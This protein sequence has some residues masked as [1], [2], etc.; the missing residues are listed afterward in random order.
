MDIYMEDV[1]KSHSLIK[2][3]MLFWNMVCLDLVGYLTNYMSIGV[4][5]TVTVC[6]QD[7]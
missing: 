3:Y 5:I 7:R 1:C 2:I 6:K 4:S